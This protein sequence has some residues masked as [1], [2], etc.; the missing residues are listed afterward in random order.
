MAALA[1]IVV[2]A[3]LVGVGKPRK[4]TLIPALFM[5]VTTVAALLYQSYD[6][7]LV[8]GETWQNYLLGGLALLLCGLAAF[9]AMEARQ[10]IGSLRKSV[11]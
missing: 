4:Y 1:L 9:I 8:K 10:V 6:F 5:L 11:H 2:S 3:W 7:L